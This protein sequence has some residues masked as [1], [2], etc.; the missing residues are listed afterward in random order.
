MEFKLPYKCNNSACHKAIESKFKVYLFVAYA[1]N[2]VTTVLIKL[3]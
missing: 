3:I 1:I 2:F